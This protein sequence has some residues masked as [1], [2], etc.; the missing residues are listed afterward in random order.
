MDCQGLG[1]MGQLQDLK[2]QNHSGDEVHLE[3]E[4]QRN[5]RA[6]DAFFPKRGKQGDIMEF[7]APV[8]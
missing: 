1:Q 7:K 6:S 4:S 2:K 8:H 5:V 3:W